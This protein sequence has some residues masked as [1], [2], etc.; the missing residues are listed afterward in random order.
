MGSLFAAILGV[1]LLPVSAF[2]WL[3]AFIYLPN[4][5]CIVL[6]LLF[7]AI[8]G[9]V[10]QARGSSILGAIMGAIYF[11]PGGWLITILFDDERPKCPECRGTVIKGARRCKNCGVMLPSPRRPKNAP[12]PSD[13][14]RRRPRQPPPA[15][16]AEPHVARMYRVTGRDRNSEFQATSH[17]KATSK[18]EAAMI[19]AGRGIIVAKVSEA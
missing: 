17:I 4:V 14:R 18:G 1:I 10:G 3:W 15:E 12:P 16:K 8:G 2:L 13:K 9:A 7:A 6:A 19:A 11:G 5:V